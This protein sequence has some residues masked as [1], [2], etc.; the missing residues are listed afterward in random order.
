MKTNNLSWGWGLV[1]AAATPPPP[2]PE[3]MKVCKGFFEILIHLE[4]RFT[5]WRRWSAAICYGRTTE[6]LWRQWME[7]FL[8]RS[9][10]NIP[11]A[12]LLTES[13]ISSK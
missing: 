11:A 1:K 8:D 9:L 13:L 12:L 5:T 4:T 2:L 10:G 6:L 3:L 7:M